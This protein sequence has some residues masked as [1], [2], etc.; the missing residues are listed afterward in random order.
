MLCHEKLEGR[1]SYEKSSITKQ[2]KLLPQKSGKRDTQQPHWAKEEGQTKEGR[3]AADDGY[4][5]LRL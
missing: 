5:L 1:I 3:D 4:A 2:M